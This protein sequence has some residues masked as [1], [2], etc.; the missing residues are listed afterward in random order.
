MECFK[1]L[2]FFI[3]QKKE[4]GI[5]DKPELGGVTSFNRPTRFQIYQLASIKMQHILLILPSGLLLFFYE[6]C[7]Y[8]QAYLIMSML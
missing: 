7:S 2:H 8:V 5:S 3:I 4:T 1:P 6:L